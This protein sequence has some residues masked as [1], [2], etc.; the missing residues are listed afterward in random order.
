MKRVPCHTFSGVAEI[1][2]ACEPER[3]SAY[4]F[5]EAE[6]LSAWRTFMYTI[7]NEGLR[8]VAS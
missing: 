7:Q 3:S 1:S 8:I 6:I 5:S 4:V 2:S